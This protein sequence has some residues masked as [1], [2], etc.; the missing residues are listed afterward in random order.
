LCQYGL[1]IL[2]SQTAIMIMF[3]HATVLN[4]TMIVDIAIV[5]RVTVELFQV[6]LSVHTQSITQL[7]HAQ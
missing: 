2:L 6:N 5:V 3:G 1:A 7:F 4:M